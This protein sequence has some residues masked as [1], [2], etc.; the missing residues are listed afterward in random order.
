MIAI[1]DKGILL[2]LHRREE[3][4]L[5]ETEQQYGALCR[6]AALD[7]LGNAQDADECLNDALLTVWNSIPPAEPEN[8]PAFLLKIV[9]NAALDRLR[10]RQRGKRGGGQQD[11]PLEELADMLAGSE[12]VEQ[13]VERREMLEAVTRFLET[14]PKK[15]RDLF[16]RRYWRFSSAA[17]LA[18]DFDMTENHVQVMLSRIRSR[19]RKALRKEG[20]L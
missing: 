11:A 4:A 18:R 8:Y 15:Q 13:Q 1:T 19:L 9:R 20:L 10:S 6:S 14:L 3:Q 12:N 17:D 7:I 16:L 5:R 2:L